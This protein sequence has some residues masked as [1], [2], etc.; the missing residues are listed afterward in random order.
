KLRDALSPSSTIEALVLT[1]KDM[2]SYLNDMYG[3]KIKKD[4]SFFYEV[5]ID[6][7]L[8]FILK[9]YQAH[10]AHPHAQAYQLKRLLQIKL[11]LDAGAKPSAMT[12]GIEKLTMY[13]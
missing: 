7:A 2:R 10:L 13:M 11:L 5:E 1:L 6:T 3:M 4:Y 12:G 9:D 8:G